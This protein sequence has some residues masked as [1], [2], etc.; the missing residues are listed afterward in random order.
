MAEKQQQAQDLLLREVYFV[1][2]IGR[3]TYE[4]TARS[5]AT[6]I[7][8][9]KARVE[10]LQQLAALPDIAEIVSLAAQLQR[11]G[12]DAFWQ[13]APPN[14][15]RAVVEGFVQRV[16]VGLPESRF[17]KEAQVTLHEWAQ[18]FTPKLPELPGHP[19]RPENLYLFQNQRLPKT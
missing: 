8:S 2:L 11:F 18:V 3:D 4:D 17:V 7:I 12:L 1:G 16:D 6:A 9:L 10:E 15:Q 14:A 5:T 19:G 13:D